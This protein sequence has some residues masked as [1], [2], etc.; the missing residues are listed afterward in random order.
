MHR[1]QFPRDTAE[2]HR[3]KS[4][5]YQ[6]H[7]TKTSST[8]QSTSNTPRKH[9]KTHMSDTIDEQLHVEPQKQPHARA[10][11]DKAPTGTR[12]RGRWCS[13]PCARCFQGPWRTA[14][15]KRTRLLDGID[16]ITLIIG[17]RGAPTRASSN[18][19]SLRLPRRRWN[20][21]SRSLLSRY[22]AT[23]TY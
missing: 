4:N 23:R 15:A 1:S 13:R 5:K 9:I 7:I 22:D 11:E 2:T 19:A 3:N 6:N 14:A 20:R 18:P 17:L 21:Q 12:E 16:R 8:Y 10:H